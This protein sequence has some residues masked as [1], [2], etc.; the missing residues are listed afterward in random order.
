LPYSEEL[1]GIGVRRGRYS[2]RYIFEKERKVKE[3]EIFTKK[4]WKK[5]NLRR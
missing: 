2:G 4:N 3:I 5:K 1:S